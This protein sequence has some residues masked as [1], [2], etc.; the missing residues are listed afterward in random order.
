M[1][2]PTSELATITWEL[3]VTVKSIDDYSET[4]DIGTINGGASRAELLP[5]EHR[6]TYLYAV[7]MYSRPGIA[8]I[9]TKAGHSYRLKK[10]GRYCWGGCKSGR[11]WIEDETTGEIVYGHPRF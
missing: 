11:F 10:M 6:I 8:V 2:V 9:D 1:G 4:F 3:G 7:H 5:G